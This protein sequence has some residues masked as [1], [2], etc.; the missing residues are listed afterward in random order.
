[1]LAHRRELKLAKGEVADLSVEIWP[2]GTVF[3]AGE[4]LRVVL[5]G[6]DIYRYPKDIFA[7]HNDTVNR[8][9]HVVHAGGKYD[10]YLLVPVISQP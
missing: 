8:G 6:T 7:N 2:S 4:M 3:E 5:Q 10:S 9:T 1:V